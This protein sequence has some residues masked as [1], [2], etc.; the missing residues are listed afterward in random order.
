MNRARI[1]TILM[2]RGAPTIRRRRLLCS[3]PRVER[4]AETAGEILNELPRRAA[5]ARAARRRPFERL[6]FKLSE[7]RVEAGVFGVAM[8]HGEV[9]V[10]AAMMEAEPEAEAIGQRHFL[11]DGF[12]RIDGGR[13]LVVHHLA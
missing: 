6:G 11:L 10:L 7:R 12:A 5:G 8:D 1:V 13:A 2:A 9:I 3:T 4:L